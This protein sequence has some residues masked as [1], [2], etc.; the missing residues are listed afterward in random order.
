MREYLLTIAV[1]AAV[2]YLL[3]GV[4][5]AVAH[6]WGAVPEIRDRDVHRF[7]T[8]RL[9]GVAMAG[10]LL[11]A[12]VVASALPRLSVV[13][14]FSAD[15]RAVLAAAT[16]IVLVGVADDVWDLDAVTKL[17]GQLVAG[18]LLVVN[19]LQLYWLPLPS[20]PLVL[21][22]PLAGVLTVFTVLVAVNAVNFVD[23]LDGLAAGV[24]GIGAAAFF[25]YSYILAVELDLSRMTM[26]ALIS[27]SL[28][29]IC[30]GFL[31]A[32]V[33]RARIFM[34]DSGSMLI[35]LLLAAGSISLTG[36]LDSQVVPSTSF[37]PAVLPLVLPF[38]V[39]AVPFLDLVAAIWRRARA[40]RSV[41]APD[42][43]HLHHRLL[44]RGH[45]HRRTVAILWV[46]AAVVSF[47]LVLIALW[48]SAW[49]VSLVVLAVLAVV[50]L[51][52][53]V[54]RVSEPV[55]LP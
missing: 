49:T 36:Q 10:G 43:Q 3:V 20:G 54:P 8:P 12:F 16:V 55:P 29:G 21:S 1:A 18:G 31:P 25:T 53:L 46:W 6:R 51:T 2:T 30:F 7:A 39:I 26:P 41:F 19:G 27:A 23:G 15:A 5:G 42:K 9:G 33:N 45:S 4:A 24:V 37:L 14:E 40:G 38:A 13:F 32:N 44:E 34:G 22:P 17:A 28:C 11:A 35:G 52:V 50:M 47:G 48:P